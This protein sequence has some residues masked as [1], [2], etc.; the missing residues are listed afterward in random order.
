MERLETSVDD[1]PI[2]VEELPRMAETKESYKGLTLIE[3]VN[4][5]GGTSIKYWM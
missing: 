5:Q 4:Y 1:M 3:E 2:D